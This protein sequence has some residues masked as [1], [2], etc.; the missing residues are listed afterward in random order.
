MQWGMAAEVFAY[1]F[2][3]EKIKLTDT[4]Y[5][6]LLFY[7]QVVYLLLAS[8][9][10]ALV[11]RLGSQRSLMIA[12]GSSCL[13]GTTA[14][15]A[16]HGYWSAM[17]FGVL[18]AVPAFLAQ[19]T[20]GKWTVDMYPRAQYGQFASAAAAVGAG[21]AAILSPCFGAIVDTMDHYYRLC[22]IIPPIFNACS[23]ATAIILYCY[24]AKPPVEQGF[25]V[26]PL[27]HVAAPAEANSEPV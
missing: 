1:L 19:L 8:P 24:W 17:V 27:A 25:E 15:F 14:F 18:V 5:G 6:R 22:L 10:G 20:L 3:T 9:F 2:Y 7:T 26:V 12:L 21:G 16:I 4:T 11:D 23:L 13:L